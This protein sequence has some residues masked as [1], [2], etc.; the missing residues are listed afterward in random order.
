MERCGDEKKKWEE[1]E[2][3]EESKEMETRGKWTR[4]RLIMT[5]KKQEK[6]MP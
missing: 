1:G 2:R 5:R 6:A 3:K 4:E